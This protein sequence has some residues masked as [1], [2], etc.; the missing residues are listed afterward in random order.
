M[1]GVLPCPCEW[2]LQLV[3]FDQL[4]VFM[5]EDPLRVYLCVACDGPFLCQPTGNVKLGMKASR[6]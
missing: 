6:L 5:W 2:P 1:T 3:P 4:Y